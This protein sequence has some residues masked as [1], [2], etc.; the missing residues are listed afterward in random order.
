MRCESFPLIQTIELIV[1]VEA[2]TILNKGKRSRRVIS[3][4]IK[5]EEMIESCATKKPLTK[6]NK[7]NHLP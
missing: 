5:K 6:D 3:E 2:F 7:K 1:P 4:D